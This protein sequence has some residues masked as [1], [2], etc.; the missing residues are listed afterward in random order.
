MSETE[1]QALYQQNQ[2]SKTLPRTS[3]TITGFLPGGRYLVHPLEVKI[4]YDDG[5]VIVSEPHIHIHAVGTT[6]AIALPEFRHILMEELDTL[7]SDE[8]ELGPRLQTELRYLRNL[9]GM[10]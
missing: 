6:M 3:L 4:A 5:E 2:Q 10:V 1:H 7:T 8:A 9:T